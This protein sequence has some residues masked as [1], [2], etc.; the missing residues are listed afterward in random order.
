MRKIKI[1]KQILTSAILT[2]L[3]LVS[4]CGLA[5]ESVSTD[6]PS[7][8]AIE[9]PIPALT[10]TPTI[11]PP[12]GLPP[13]IAAIFGEEVPELT[14]SEQGI[15]TAENVRWRA[16]YEDGEWEVLPRP[17]T[18]FDKELLEAV[19]KDYV[20]KPDTPDTWEGVIEELKRNPDYNSMIGTRKVLNTKTIVMHLS[21]L[22]LNYEEVSLEGQ[23]G[24]KHGD[25]AIVGMMANSSYPDKLF[26]LLLGVKKDGENIDYLRSIER[27]GDDRGFLSKDNYNKY[28]GK[29]CS[30]EIFYYFKDDN[31]SKDELLVIENWPLDIKQMIHIFESN[32]RGYMQRTTED[33]INEEK[34]LKG[35]RSES[36]V[37]L[38][39]EMDLEAGGDIGLVCS[40]TVN[41][42][43]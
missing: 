21:G 32:P 19:K 7:P 24:F 5:S 26:P 43:D 3:L 40:N 37:K 36:F 22:M 11:T 41:I 4:G 29:V 23:P 12:T 10:I 16:T 17:T 30:F 28:S 38:I 39:N 15:Y 14:K 42:F 8:T 1:K 27:R 33:W 2:S 20:A 6:T 35:H 34:Y 13:E 25:T 31:W 9:T 18:G